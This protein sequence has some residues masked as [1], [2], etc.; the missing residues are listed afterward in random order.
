MLEQGTQ[1]ADEDVPR[2]AVDHGRDLAEQR[3]VDLVRGVTDPDDV[4]D[5]PLFCISLA[6]SSG[7]PPCPSVIRATRG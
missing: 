4:Q 5:D 3:L 6:M 7:S 2:L 1:V